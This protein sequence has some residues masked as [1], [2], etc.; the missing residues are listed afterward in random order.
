M[1]TSPLDNDETNRLARLRE[2]F[3]LDSEPEPAFDAIALM[4]SQVCG[5]PMAMITLVDADRQWFKAAVGTNGITETPRAVAFCA[6]TILSDDVLVIPDTVQD[7]RFADSPLVTAG[8]KVRFYAGAPLVLPGGERI[9]SLCVTGPTP[10]GLND[11][12]VQMLRSLADV[13]TKTV[14]MRGDLITKTLAVR[15]RY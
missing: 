9:G 1:P 11:Q 3:I 5:V 6:H 4:A 13:V 15:S 10:A 8:P 7:A 2:L 12:Q 14:V